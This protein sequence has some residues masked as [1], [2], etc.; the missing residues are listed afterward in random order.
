MESL[1]S[2]LILPPPYFLFS[3]KNKVKSKSHETKIK[4]INIK[5][6]WIN[7]KEEILDESVNEGCNG[8]S[9][10]EFWRRERD[11]RR[12]SSGRRLCHMVLV[13]RF[14]CWFQISSHGVRGILF[15]FSIFFFL[16]CYCDVIVSVLFFNL[17]SFFVFFCV[18]TVMLLFLF[19]SWIERGGELLM[20]I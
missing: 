8:G 17:F 19:W 7:I 3:H 1:F 13:L 5:L 4:I 2:L 14:C 15:S 9:D 11:L 16:C 18:A 6:S 20:V 12:W 10:G